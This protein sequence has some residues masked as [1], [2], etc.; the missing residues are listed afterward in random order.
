MLRHLGTSR[1]LRKIVL[2]AVSLILR[3]L[4]ILDKQYFPYLPTPPAKLSD[5]KQVY[6]QDKAEA[7]SLKAKGA[8][9][10]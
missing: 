5:Y 2:V 9:Q 3:F 7:I 4:E 10:A 8:K 1:G 6:M